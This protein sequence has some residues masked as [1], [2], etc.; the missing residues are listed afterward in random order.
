[1]IVQPHEEL[2]PML[3]RLA[4]QAQQSPS[5]SSNRRIALNQLI[6]QIW[7]SQQLGHPQRYHWPPDTYE[8]LYNEALQ[9][10]LLEVCQK[11]DNYKPERP[12][13][14]WV[15]CLLNYN[16]LAVVRE[17]QHPKIVLKSIKD[18]D[19]LV[20]YSN[21]CPDS[22]Q[23]LRR[24]LEEDPEN[25]LKTVHIQGRVDVTFQS[26]AIARY[27]EDQSWESLSTRLGISIQTLCSFFNRQ[28]R[29]LTPYFQRHLQS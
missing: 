12:V 15:N 5:N 25:L 9:R 4:Q 20:E 2:A 27:I 24:F 11:I 19:R 23:I 18:L 16:F 8:D 29:K 28:L 3:R 22:H 6:Y 7:H 26:L 14:A 10:T 17:H 21:N 1:M 13:M